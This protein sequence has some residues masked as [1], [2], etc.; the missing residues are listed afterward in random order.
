MTSSG[1]LGPQQRSRARDRLGDEHVDV[2]VIGGGVTGAGIALDAAARGLRVALVEKRDL[3]SGTSS[4]S[5]KLIHG[6]LRYLEQGDLGLVREALRERTVLLETVCPHLVRPVPFL[7]PLRHRGWE[8][9]YAGAGVWLYDRFAG[10]SPLP[11]HR[12]LS[13]REALRCAPALRGD[14]VVGAIRYWD[15]QVDDARHTV[16]LA[17]TAARH[18]ATVLTDVEVTGLLR[19]GE[20]VAGA[21]VTDRAQGE[22]M[23]VRAHQTVSAAGVWS[24]ELQRLTGQPAVS[25]H[26]SKG[27]H[28]VVPRDRLDAATALILRTERSVLLVIPWPAP[29]YHRHWLIGTTDTGWPL[30]KD[31]PTAS[32]ADIDYLLARLNEVVRHPLGRADIVAVYAG[33][34]PLAGKG[35]GDTAKASRE[36]TVTRPVPGLVV[37]TGGKYTTYRVMAADAVDAAA[38]RLSQPVPPSSTA[39]L[40]L[41]GARGLSAVW[42]VKARLAREAGLPLSRLE[43]LLR[44]YGALTTELCDALADRPELGRPIPGAPRYLEVEAW[45]AAAREGARDLDDVLSRRTRIAMETADRGEAAAEA[46]APVIGDVLGW[47]AHETAAAVARYR[48]WVRAQRTAESQPDDASAVAALTGFRSSPSPTPPAPRSRES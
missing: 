12:H 15:A 7:Y 2:L 5:S 28:L 47:T 43:H 14:A 35:D 20:A 33:L 30:D 44:R 9:A 21:V 38:E 3:A 13:R 39:R 40:P 25:V 37:I 34:R 1:E 8:R 41:L 10:R 26:A 42:R 18:G 16:E 27:I 32:R 36:H 4:R 22:T 11:R 29:P 6:G 23:T 19:D 17:R 24:E 45:Y 48:A 31:R 46:V